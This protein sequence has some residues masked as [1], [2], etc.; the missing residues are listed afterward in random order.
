MCKKICVTALTAV[1][2][3]AS[4]FAN[5]AGNQSV[6]Q[7]S[8][9]IDG[10]LSGGIAVLNGSVFYLDTIKE[11]NRKDFNGKAF[12]SAEVNGFDRLV[13]QP[14]S[15][16]LDTAGDALAAAA[17]LTPGLLFSGA[18]YSGT[19]V[20]ASEWIT[21]GTMYTETMLLAYGVKELG[22]LCINRPR[23]YCYDSDYTVSAGDDGDWDKSFPSGHTTIAFAGATF[24]SYVFCTLY[25]DSTMKVP[26]V[27]ASYTLALTTA[28]LRV[29]SRNH[30]MS[31][32]LAG[33]AIGTVC[34]F[35]VPYI[36]TRIS[37]TADDDTKK[38]D[39]LSFSLTPWQM[40]VCF[41]F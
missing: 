19:E 24:T 3:M 12:D 4:L 21:I 33:A 32:A 37:G 25:P 8:P 10:A 20:S 5:D 22:K 34:G 2:G 6:F 16:G 13:M 41:K 38:T 40:S 36:H 30:F 28:V 31:D 26:V 29:A 11:I 18:R 27:A 14:Y 39:K 1:L 9:V 35:V 7:L 17:C 23:P 15:K